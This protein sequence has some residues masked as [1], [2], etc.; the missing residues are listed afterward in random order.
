M[1]KESLVSNIRSYFSEVYDIKLLKMKYLLG[2][3]MN[4]LGK[5]TIK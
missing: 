2:D 3:S 5:E 4:N 1:R